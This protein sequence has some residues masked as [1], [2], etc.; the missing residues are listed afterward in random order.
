MPD[1]GLF[2]ASEPLPKDAKLIIK[3]SVEVEG[4]PVYNESYDVEKLAAELS[5]DRAK[6]AE[7]WLRRVECVVSCRHKHG[8]SAC[9]TRCLTDGKACDCGSEE[10]GKQK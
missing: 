7:L 4:L 6:V 8:F 5:E 3:F 2:T 10:A 1:V 9:V